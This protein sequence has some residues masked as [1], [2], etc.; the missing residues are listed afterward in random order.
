MAHSQQRHIEAEDDEFDRLFSEIRKPSAPVKKSPSPT[1][2]K[3]RVVSFDR[4]RDYQDD[5]AKSLTCALR[6]VGARGVLVLPCGAGKTFISAMVHRELDVRLTLFLVPK[7]QLA[8]QAALAWQALNEDFEALTVYSDSERDPGGL[9][10]R[11][12]D[13]QDIA[14]FMRHAGRRVVFCT[15]QSVDKLQAAQ[16]LGAPAFDLGVFDEAHYTTGVDVH[17]VFQRALHDDQVSIHRRLFLTATP[18]IVRGRRAASMDDTSLYG[19][20]VRRMTF[21]EAIER[22]IIADYRVIVSVVDSSEVLKM[23]RDRAL[24]TRGEDAVRADLLS[25]NIAVAKAMQ[26]YELRRLIT[27]HSRVRQAQNFADS[28]HPASL[29]FSL[30]RFGLGTLSKLDLATD[31]VNG[32][33][34][35][36]RKR[37]V[38]ETL[39]N[40]QTATLISNARCLQEGIDIPDLDAVV[41]MDERHSV[42]SILQAVGRVLRKPD[43]RPDKIGYVILPVVHEGYDF[44]F[45]PV[46][47]VL[48]ALSTEDEV[49]TQFISDFRKRGRLRSSNS[50]S[51]ES[52]GAG[53]SVVVFD[54]MLS[55]LDA[56]SVAK[57]ILPEVLVGHSG[58]ESKFAALLRFVERT[59]Y[60]KPVPKYVD[61]EGIK[62]GRWVSW[63][64]QLYRK[65]QLHASRVQRL[66]TLPGWEWWVYEAKWE[67]GFEH[68]V[69]YVESQGH[70][71][72]PT[73]FESLDGFRLGDWVTQQYRAHRRNRLSDERKKRLE[74]LSGWMWRRHDE[75]WKHRFAV[76]KKFLAQA[77][78]ADEIPVTPVEGVDL[79]YFVNYCRQQQRKGVLDLERVTELESL[80]GWM[81]GLEASFNEDLNGR[82]KWGRGKKMEETERA[83]RGN[84]A[85]VHFSIPAFASERGFVTCP[86]AGAC[87]QTCYARQGRMVWGPARRA[88]E[89]NLALLRLDLKSETFVDNVLD[90]LYQLKPT[91]VRLHQAGDFFSA[92]YYRAWLEVARRRPDVVFWVYT[93][94]INLLRWDDHPENFRVVQSL[95]GRLDDRV[96]LKRP[97]ARWFLKP[98]ELLDAGYV[99]GTS[100]EG[101]LPAIRGDIRIGLVHH[102]MRLLDQASRVAIAQQPV[103][104]RLNVVAS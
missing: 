1:A 76:L 56:V 31:H 68:L 44:S 27:F 18:R 64:R 10:P 32:T 67:T 52:H 26:K 6:E 90:D 38:L 53:S 99:D 45:S 91:H 36:N 33:M 81:W 50:P 41:F 13:P 40:P 34:S 69:E 46:M 66:E 49:I 100:S 43:S 42:T 25:A 22:K 57:A 11:T 65:G 19:R 78:P 55:T 60:A 5:A 83:L 23:V 35:M 73:N 70:A 102:G 4:S 51:R 82:Y 16:R 98:K 93:K 28:N 62:L 59:G 95:M 47:S 15:Y 61:P 94:S 48:E 77:D 3:R 80:P 103:G 96:D 58:W 63:I 2:T 104:G 85:V 92:K 9:P 87:A 101:D 74:T 88:Y 12:T 21:R 29:A 79:R 75:K 24:V 72:V 86:Q 30:K 71:A 39:E 37:T 20:V 84:A 17:G 89:S 54:S 8:V 97:H 14:C 7:I